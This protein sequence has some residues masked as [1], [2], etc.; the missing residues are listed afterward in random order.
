MSH[1]QLP[2]KPVNL[3]QLSVLIFLLLFSRLLSAQPIISS[4]APASG[5]VGTTV[6]ISG[7]GFNSTASSNHVYFGAVKA[8]ITTASPT[9]LTMVAPAG[10]S[11]KPITVTTGGLTTYSVKPFQVTFPGGGSL[12]FSSFSLPNPNATTGF[13]TSHVTADFDGDGKPDVIVTNG[14]NNNNNL[15]MNTISVYR[16]TTS[17]TNISFAPKF[18]STVGAHLAAVVQAD[19]ADVDMDGKPDVITL[20]RDSRRIAV[21]RNTSTP[22]AISFAEREEFITG[23]DPRSLKVTDVDKDGKPDICFSNYFDN[24]FS[25]LRNTGSPGVISFDVRVSFVTSL[26][27]YYMLADDMDTD[28]K[29]DII[30]T[31]FFTGSTSLFR[32]TSVPG[33]ISFDNRINVDVSAIAYEAGTGDLNGDGKPELIV[34]NGSTQL[35]VFRNTGTPGTIS[36]DLPAVFTTGSACRGV[37]LDDADGDGKTDVAITCTGIN[38]VVVH[39]N[40]STAGTISFDPHVTYSLGNNGCSSVIFTDFNLDGKPD[41]SAANQGASNF[42][43]FRNQVG[44]PYISSISPTSGAAGTTVTITGAYFTGVTGVSFGGVAAS[45]FTVVSPTTITA[46]VGNGATGDVVVTGPGGT[47]SYSSFTYTAQPVITS[48]TPTVTGNGGPV[49]ITGNFFTGT[50]SVSFGGTPAQSFI[51]VNA[52][53]ITAIVGAGSSGSVAVTNPN[54]SASLAGFRYAVPPVITSFNPV[55]GAIGSQVVISGTD[56]DPVAANNIVYFGAVRA[57]VVSGTITSLTVTVPAGASYRPITVTKDFYTASSIKPFNV[58]FPDGGAGFEYNFFSPRIDS[59]TI[60][61]PIGNTA[62]DFDGDGKIDLAVCNENGVAVYRNTSTTTSSSVG[63]RI[64]VAAGF[65]PQNIYAADINSDGKKDLVVASFDINILVNTSTSGNISFAA[66]VPLTGGFCKEIAIADLDRDGRQDLVISYTS[67]SGVTVF[68]NTSYNGVVSFL[69]LNDYIIGN[70]PNRITLN[71]FDRDGRIDMAVS[72]YQGLAVYR[73]TTTGSAISFGGRQDYTLLRQV[74]DL[75]SADI[76]GDGAPDLIT[77]NYFDSSFS[78]LRNTSTGPLSISF[79]TRLEFKSADGTNCLAIADFNGDTK[80]DVAA[81]NRWDSS[82]T[83]FKNTSIAGTIQFNEKASYRSGREPLFLQAEDW[84]GDGFPDIT[85]VNSLSSSAS[86]FLNQHNRP[87]ITGISPAN[88]VVGTPVTIS[89]FNFNGTTAVQFGGTAAAS[90]TVNSPVSISAITG[91]G[92]NG[93][94]T[95]TTALGTATYQSFSFAPPVI[96]SFAPITAAPGTAVT[97]SGTNFSVIPANNIVYFGATK[98]EVTAATLTTL[99]VTVPNGATHEPITVTAHQM[100]SY[101]PK[102]FL[103]TFAGAG[104]AITATSFGDR[105]DSLFASNPVNTY[106]PLIRDFD[107]DGKPDVAVPGDDGNSVFVFRNTSSGS[108]VSFEPRKRLDAGLYPRYLASGDFDGD[109]KADL[110]SAIFDQKKVM[111]W[112]NT[113]VSGQ[114]SFATATEYTTLDPDPRCVVVQDLD[115]DGRPD[116]VIVNGFGIV[117]VR[118][119]TS[120]PG[121]ISFDIGMEIARSNLPVFASVGDFTNDGKPDIV[122]S[123]N[124]NVRL[125]FIRNTS[126][127]GTLSF[128]FPATTIQAAGLPWG[129]TL[130][131]FDNDGLTDMALHNQRLPDGPAMQVFRN[132]SNTTSLSFGLA[133]TYAGGLKSTGGLSSGDLNGDG[134]ADIIAIGQTGVPDSI[135]VFRNTTAAA[136]QTSFDA[137]VNLTVQTNP[138]NTFICD[139]NGDGKPDIVTSGSGFS[140]LLNKTGTITG[141]PVISAGEMGIRPFPVPFQQSLYIH[142]NK[143]QRQV[144]TELLLADGTPVRVRQD[145]LIQANSRLEMDTRSLPAGIYLLHIRTA[146]AQTTIKLVKL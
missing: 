41:M 114:I 22:G 122:L 64:T 39:R 31:N 13:P 59:T 83:V 90:F 17:G 80:P 103:P 127:P 119:N 4:F 3:I 116:L 68:R 118:R 124:T 110:V 11:Y 141:L 146:T 26:N 58:T 42:M 135:V 6:N 133:G 53:T 63:P 92:S 131:D 7:S 33:A 97:I 73:N 71:D 10:S 120:V 107:S 25:V 100:T 69:E 123:M 130:G 82:M 132:S 60:T 106:N 46:V 101:S 91:E 32:N 9:S 108:Q 37:A 15:P 16:N 84:N 43:V 105:V 88:G 56:F 44:N 20:N 67:G 94:V 35:S 128:A 30:I 18:D 74:L 113:S 99:N 126:V 85:M 79:S 5:P 55:S 86:L 117:E 115:R 109:G 50:T 137:R 104:G 89:G 28:G 98:A 45:S 138:T 111:L 102:F 19:I 87:V 76:D 2:M 121:Q 81:S 70:D 72:F 51:V 1:D 112:R 96:N 47:G 143:V 40:T 21:L 78:V 34:T 23:N 142:F 66:P 36:L 8:N 144:S 125:D 54:G 93:A 12:S 134:K 75:K 65:S 129:T 95:V 48:F 139:M 77:A 24:T 140:V 14:N 57:T 52:T 49:T 38:A 62:A 136:G 29:T 61:A 27:P 145:G